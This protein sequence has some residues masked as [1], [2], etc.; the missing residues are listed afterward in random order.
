MLLKQDQM[1]KKAP[2]GEEVEATEV[3]EDLVEEEDLE[4][5]SVSEDQNM[6]TEMLSNE[7]KKVVLVNAEN[8]ISNLVL[9]Q[10]LPLNQHLVKL[11]VK[12]K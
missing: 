4:V 8:L 3:I 11:T 6:M 10:V 12:P 5:V 7:V 9:L 2:N 1:I